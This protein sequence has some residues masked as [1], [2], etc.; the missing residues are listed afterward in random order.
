MNFPHN[1]FCLWKSLKI[2]CLDNMVMGIS[3][4]YLDNCKV[5][6]GSVSAYPKEDLMIINKTKYI[7]EM[8]QCD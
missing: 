7:N 5:N 4:F 6:Y 1:I 3:Y 2:T 8:K